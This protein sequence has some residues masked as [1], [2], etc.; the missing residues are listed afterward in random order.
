MSIVKT[1]RIRVAINLLPRPDQR[2]DLS[3]GLSLLSP[4]TLET[5]QRRRLPG[6]HCYKLEQQYMMSPYRYSI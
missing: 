5:D 1:N 2:R 4:S 6:W 3:R